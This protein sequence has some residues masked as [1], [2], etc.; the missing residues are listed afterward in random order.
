VLAG[1]RAL[2][3]S[4]TEDYSVAILAAQQYFEK[5][6]PSGLTGSDP[7]FSV[8]ENGTVLRAQSS[9]SLSTPFL[10][11]IGIDSLRLLAELSGCCSGLS[12]G[13]MVA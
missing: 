10:S 13:R 12:S 9:L 6:R 7:V 3:V 4:G 1:G 5:M 8:V 11:L 2:Q